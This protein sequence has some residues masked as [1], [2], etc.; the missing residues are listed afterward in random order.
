MSIKDCFL[1]N[2]Y[3]ICRKRDLKLGQKLEIEI[4]DFSKATPEELNTNA[5]LCYVKLSYFK[6]LKVTLS[7]FICNDALK[8]IVKNKRWKNEEIF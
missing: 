1:L 7:Y 4:K 5:M 6:L 3:N 8:A 2:N